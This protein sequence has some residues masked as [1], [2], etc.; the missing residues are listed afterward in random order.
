MTKIATVVRRALVKS[1]RER[2]QSCM[3]QEKER[4][5][6][7]FVRLSGYHRKYAIEVLN[8]TS[9]EPPVSLSAARR[10]R[11]PLYDQAVREALIVLWEASDRICGKRLKA[12]LPVLVPSLERHGHLQLNAVVREKLMATSAASIDRLLKAARAA[13]PRK[14]KRLA[15]ALRQSIPVRTFADWNDPLP[16]NTEVDL[17]LHCGETTAGSYVHTLT[18]TD[19]ASGWTE[20]LA[21]VMRERTL[22]VDAIEGIRPL[23]PF[24]LRAIDTDNGLEFLNDTLLQYC[25]DHHIEFTRSRP[26]QKNDQAWVEQKNGAI[27]RRL[28]GY[29]RLEGLAAAG[30]LSRLY[31]TS[32]L[33][34]NFFQPS[35]KLA[36]KTRT[37]ARVTKRY[38]PP[39]TP[40]ARLLASQAIS[41]EVKA[42]LRETA[43]R[44]DP[45]ALL[46]EIRKM[47]GHLVA[48]VDQ[49][50]AYTPPQH[51]NQ[52]LSGFLSGL[53][54]AWRTG[55]VRP[56]DCTKPK[57][58]R[59]WRSRKDPFES[60]WPQVRDWLEIEPDRTAKELFARLRHEH[61]GT[62]SAGQ[63]RTLQRR[64][65]DWRAQAA[66]KLVFGLDLTAEQP[67]PAESETL[68][69]D[70][71]ENCT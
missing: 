52:D 9:E 55:E 62:F 68:G 45:L 19:I 61:P 5:L 8:R 35:F 49:G 7:E 34:V 25:R 31:A 24:P 51:A 32:R 66:R 41:S 59:Y 65:K 29:R 3:R 64:V 47:Q 22:I 17:V 1:L 40:C 37:G 14:R 16:G 28:V 36:S 23:L 13:V 38:Y 69:V 11:P 43:A 70:S 39:Q 60:T 18:L 63:L 21:L 12:L 15:T 46:E 6:E 53:S 58:A 27:V 54:T 44:L 10:G 71:I 42:Q 48:L 33:F 50:R 57:P 30:A 20:C 56:T 67:T 2:Y 26:Y 4:L